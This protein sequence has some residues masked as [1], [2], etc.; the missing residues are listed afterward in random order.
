MNHTFDPSMRVSPEEMLAAGEHRAIVMTDLIERYQTPV[1]VFT[2]NIPGPYK[3]F[4]RISEVF[5]KGCQ[6][7]RKYLEEAELPLIYEETILKKTGYAAL[8]CVDADPIIIKKHMMLQEEESFLG[9]VYDIDVIR[10]DGR[11]I[12]RTD[13]GM[14]PR[15]C[16]FCGGSVQECSRTYRHSVDEMIAHIRKVIGETKDGI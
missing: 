3:V 6:K 12:S 16:P 13:I 7:I 11:K 5:E 15:P 2:L 10:M 9:R 14:P 4:G 1:I 8:F